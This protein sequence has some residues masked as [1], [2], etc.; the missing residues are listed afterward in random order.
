VKITLPNIFTH[1]SQ[2]KIFNITSSQAT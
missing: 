2:I 1:C